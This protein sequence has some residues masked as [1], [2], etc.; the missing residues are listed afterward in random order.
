MFL[1]E[2]I[3]FFIYYFNKIIRVCMGLMF[4]MEINIYIKRINEYF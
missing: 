4:K 1:I 3:C 2:V